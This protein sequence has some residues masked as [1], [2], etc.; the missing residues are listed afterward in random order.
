[1]REICPNAILSQV[2]VI[3]THTRRLGFAQ[4]PIGRDIIG[5]VSPG[6][7]GRGSERNSFLFSL[8]FLPSVET[9]HRSLAPTPV[10]VGD[11]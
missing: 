1:M 6:H 2:C 11:A 4:F 5:G 9:V 10:C 3:P 7:G 8:H